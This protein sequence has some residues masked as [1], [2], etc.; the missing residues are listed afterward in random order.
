MNAHALRERFKHRTQHH[1]H[2]PGTHSPLRYTNGQKQ[3]GP[4][5]ASFVTTPDD[6]YFAVYHASP[7]HNCNRFA[8]VEEM[9]FDAASGWPYI[10][11]DSNGGGGAGGDVLG[12]YVRFEASA[13]TSRPLEHRGGVTDTEE[14]ARRVD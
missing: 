10:D 7:G 4:G 14:Q 1:Q 6:R 11:F 9:K 5:H 8:F 2:H 12:R 3:V 13:L